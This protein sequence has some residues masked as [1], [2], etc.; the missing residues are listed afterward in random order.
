MEFDYRPTKASCAM[1]DSPHDWLLADIGVYEAGV[2]AQ[3]DGYDAVCIDS[4]SDSGIGALRS[5]LDIPVIAPARSAYTVALNFAN[6]FGIVTYGDPDGGR[7][8]NNA[9]PMLYKKT[10][11][12]YGLMAHCAAIEGAPIESDWEMLLT[13]KE[14]QAFPALLNAAE[15]CVEA[16]ADAIILG[17]TTLYQAAGHLAENLPV[18][19]INPGPLTYKVAEL[20]LSMGLTHSRMS[21]PA[22]A[23][24]KLDMAH[25]MLDAAAAHEAG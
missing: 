9:V 7:A 4:M 14:E 24:P 11:K 20:A 22:P 18:P 15:R 16:G 8:A 23:V 19:V 6:S 17:S 21:F 13:G 5:A 3:G 12:E 1:F 25:A 2:S 10:L